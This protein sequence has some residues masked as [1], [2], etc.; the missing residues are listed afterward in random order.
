MRTLINKV[1]RRYRNASISGKFFVA[2]LVVLI[3]PS[4]FLTLMMIHYLGNQAKHQAYDKAKSQLSRINVELNNRLASA[5]NVS[6]ICLGQHEFLNVISADMRRDD[7]KL[8]KF[9]QREFRQME[10]IVRSNP[11]IEQVSFYVSNPRLYEIWHLIY[12]YDRRFPDPAY[13]HRLVAE[14]GS[15]WEAFSLGKADSLSYYRTV[16]LFH[17]TSRIPTVLEVRI[18]HARLLEALNVANSDFPSY[19]I[20][21]DGRSLGAPPAWLDEIPDDQLRPNGSVRQLHL[22]SDREVFAIYNPKLRSY[23]VN[24]V[25]NGPL[26][27]PIK[28]LYPLIGI[29]T[30]GLLLLL[31]IVL[32]LLTRRIFRRMDR[33]H[34]SMVLVSQGNMSAK[35]YTGLQRGERGDVIDALAGN[36]NHMLDEISRLMDEAVARELIAKNAQL[37]AL[38]NQ[39]HSHFLYNALES[40]RMLAVEAKQAQI[41]D[42]LVTLGQLMRY[43]LRWRSGIV[44]LQDELTHIR[45]Y[46]SFINFMEE[47]SFEL[48]IEVA[49][50]YLGYEIPKMS[51]QPLVENVVQHAAD[52]SG[53][54]HIQIQA[55]LREDRLVLVVRDN[56]RGIEPETLR[57]IHMRL[58]DNKVQRQVDAGLGLENV[59]RRLLLQ[60]GPGYGLQLTSEAGRYT[61]VALHLARQ[62]QKVGG[63]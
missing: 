53:A 7:L 5:E 1:R 46:I 10:S 41:S 34:D 40:I 37:H 43:S 54:I 13:G 26:L 3:I 11:L 14:R 44:D 25:E 36:Y 19:L 58:R 27:Q 35:V 51:I 24:A 55:E 20:V 18:S 63:W 60:F 22:P 49:D 59:H 56:G 38:Q 33:L 21:E 52:G 12:D 50:A 8:I 17:N 28:A 42:A 16:P 61:E 48:E 30:V 29:A 47:G 57:Q 31:L 2:Y 23:I 39:I 45:N 15:S 9:K 6:T 4:I 32:R 62:D